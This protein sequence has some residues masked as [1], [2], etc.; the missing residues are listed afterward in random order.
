MI[1]YNKDKN[2]KN[3]AGEGIAASLLDTIISSILPWD[4]SPIHK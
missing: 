4:K 1:R 3:G 2:S